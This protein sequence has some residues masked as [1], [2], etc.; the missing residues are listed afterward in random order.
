M[1]DILFKFLQQLK[2]CIPFHRADLGTHYRETHH[3]I[4]EWPCSMC[5]TKT[6]GVY[7]LTSHMVNMHYRG[8]F[9]C[10]AFGCTYT[11]PFR[12]QVANHHKH[13]HKPEVRVAK[14][15]LNSGPIQEVVLSNN[16]RKLRCRIAGCGRLF[17]KTSHL[18][19][20][21]LV[22]LGFKP[23]RCKWPGCNFASS[24]D[25]NV[26]SH[27]RVTHFNLPR[28]VKEQIEKNIQDE[29]DARDYLEVHEDLQT[30]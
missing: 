20:H 17:V 8:L 22:H 1:K 7:S 14:P 28:T 2:F 13:V 15:A 25:A 24:Q 16:V 19:R 3:N 11:A 12:S 4:K 23:Y 10:A 6:I 9:G 27:I 21:E 26:I 29:R 18:K 5:D 30:L